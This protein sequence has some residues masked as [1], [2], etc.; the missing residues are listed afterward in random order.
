VLP[1]IVIPHWNA[2]YGQCVRVAI[3]L[4]PQIHSPRIRPS[5]RPGYDSWI[6]PKKAKQRRQRKK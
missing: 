6:E 1:S 5:Y 3:R 2:Q 4:W